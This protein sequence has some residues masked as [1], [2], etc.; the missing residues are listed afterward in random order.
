MHNRKIVRAITSPNQWGWLGPLVDKQM[1]GWAAPGSMKG[2]NVKHSGSCRRI[3]WLGAIFLIS[4]LAMAAELDPDAAAEDAEQEKAAAT[5]KPGY[6]TGNFRIRPSLSV[7]GKYDSNIFATD[8]DTVADWI[9]VVSPQLRIDSTWTE[10]SLNFKAGAEFGRYW[11]YDAEN[12]LDYWASAEGRYN[13]SPATDLFGGLG[14]SFE[15]EGRDSPDAT[16]GGLEPTTYR[17]MN[18]HAGIKTTLGDTTYR[19]GGTYEMLDFNDAGLVINDDR[20]RDLFGFGI[21]A[22]HKLDPQNEVFL[23]ALYDER[24]YDERTDSSGYRRDSDGYRAALGLKRD[25]GSGNNAEAYVGI[26]IQDYDDKRFDS[27]SATDFGGRLTFTP[28]ES[29]KITAN[30]QRSL[31][32]TT[33]AGSPGYLS[34]ALSGRL[35]YRASPRLIPHLSFSY[36][37]ADY[38]EIGREDETYSAEAGLR[39]YVARNA[40]IS[41]G[42]RHVT[43]D[44]N[45][46]GLLFG[47]DDYEKNSIFLTFATQGYPLFEPMISDFT[48]DGELGIGVLYLSQDAFRFGRYSGLTDDGAHWNGDLIARSTDGKSGYASITALDLGL[49]SRSIRIDW[50]SQGSYRAFVDYNQIPFKDFVGRSIFDG[51]GST[52]LTLPSGWPV[53][54]TTDGMAQLA[55]SLSEVEIGTTRKKLGVGTL[56]HATDGRW[57]L[58]L[59]Y[60]TETKDGLTQMAGVNGIAPGNALSAMLPTP[61]D[62]TT[63]TLRASLG[64]LTDRSQLDLAYQSSF[65]YNNLEALAWESPFDATGPR[66]TDGSTSLPPDN[67]FHQLTLSGAHTLFGTT[68]LTG[69]ASVAAMLQ[70]EAF[71]A[72]TVDPGRRNSLPRDS[73]D[74]EVYL[75]NAL[76]TLSSRPVRGLN[77]KASYRMQKRDNDTPRETYTYSVN[78]TTSNTTQTVSNTPYSYDKRTLK[79]DAGYRINRMARLSGDVSRE[80]MERSPSEVDKTTEDKGKLKLQLKPLDNVQVSLSGGVASRTGSDYQTVSGENPL[81]RKYNI[82][83]RD[84]VSTGMDISYQPIDRLSLNLNLERS[85]DDYDATRVGLTEAQ[86]TSAMLDASYQASAEVSVYGYAGRQ[87]LESHQAGSQDTGGPAADWLV[88]NDDTV[89][90]LGLGLRWKKDDRL[91]LGTDYT[92]SRSKGETRMQSSNTL[93]PL[94]QFPDLESNIHSLRVYADYQ[95]RKDTKLKLSYRYEKY[96]ADDW[97]IDGFQPASIPEVLL[98]GEVDPN[99]TQHVVGISLVT[100]F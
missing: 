91:E 81:L 73:L 86:Q 54:D 28:T 60:D 57:T 13:L 23:Q 52:E 100:R 17:T 6:H 48:T 80:T 15:H 26:I 87:W 9:T 82:S 43:R 3:G 93:P 63:N 33:L 7:T 25:F 20:D 79:L 62:Y 47:S 71:Q 84:Q 66:G 92:L 83:D 77:L 4:P 49:D 12:Y 31:N 89:D 56:L 68:R 21:R 14:I 96:D 64:Y 85:D 78:D 97:S 36:A 40:Y 16:V 55:G 70:D 27:V 22:T 39:Y 11:D 50:G 2:S 94:S 51:V 58:S 18:A 5:K 8:R 75:Y 88:K 24:R 69:V 67:Q 29:T 44:S 59:G 72:D 42:L 19:L 45:D 99:Y 30:L 32:E 65:F 35:E 34:T 90:S 41:T 74:G 98:L 95:W 37:L 38:L 1:S 76:L 10:H 53:A 61:V 46:A